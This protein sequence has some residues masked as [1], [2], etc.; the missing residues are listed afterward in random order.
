MTPPEPADS[1]FLVQ[2]TMRDIYE[3]VKTTEAMVAQLANNMR[4]AEDWRSAADRDLRE[5]SRQASTFVTRPQH[6]ALEE[7][8]SGTVTRRELYVVVGLIAS[9]VGAASPFLAQ[10]YSR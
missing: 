3:T 6:E 9:A 2:I 1:P 7:K 8:V 4:H 5:L 10:L